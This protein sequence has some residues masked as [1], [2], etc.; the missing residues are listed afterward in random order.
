MS[1]VTQRTEFVHGF[2]RS[3]DRKEQ[4]YAIFVEL[5]KASYRVSDNELIHKLLVFGVNKQFI[6]WIEAYIEGRQQFVEVNGE[7]NEVNDIANE[8][9]TQLKGRLFADDCL[10]YTRA[11]SY[12]D[13]KKLNMTLRLITDWCNCRGMEVNQENGVMI[14]TK[15]LKKN[16]AFF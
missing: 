10:I 4:I 12:R 5:S 2:A 1:T 11:R 14:K 16:Y 3:L 15:K 8:V 6:F 9:D 13:H 7:V